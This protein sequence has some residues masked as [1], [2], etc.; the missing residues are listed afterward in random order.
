[1]K[2]VSYSLMLLLFFYWADCFRSRWPIKL[3]RNASDPKRFSN[4][5]KRLK[6]NWKT[7]NRWKHIKA[8]Y[9]DFTSLNE[10][11][12]LCAL[13][14]DVDFYLHEEKKTKKIA[15]IDHWNE[16]NKF[17]ILC[18]SIGFDF[19]QQWTKKIHTQTGSNQ[20]TFSRVSF[21]LF[22]FY[23]ISVYLYLIDKL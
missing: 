11:W 13:C 14:D 6:V 16:N 2:F 9:S 17:V 21:C 4:V 3:D 18:T 10:Q 7:G 5:N 20:T 15:W 22:K 23:C 12:R 1:M 8:H 19:V